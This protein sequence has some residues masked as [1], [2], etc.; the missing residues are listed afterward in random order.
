MRPREIRDWRNREREDW[1]FPDL[2]EID[3]FQ[4]LPPAT[5]F[6][7]AY[8]L[9]Y[10]SDWG[11][12]MPE[13]PPSKPLWRFCP[14]GNWTHWE[15]E[16]VRY[17]NRE[18]FSRFDGYNQG[19]YNGWWEDKRYLH[20]LDNW[21]LCNA[22]T[23]A[24]SLTNAQKIRV[25]SLFASRNLKRRGLRLEF[26]IFVLASLVCHYDGRKCYPHPNTKNYDPLFEEFARHHNFRDKMIRRWF[27][28]FQDQLEDGLLPEVKRQSPE[29]AANIE[30]WSL[31]GASEGRAQT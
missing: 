8:W 12:Q 18:Q 15:M 23:S 7:S 16:D 13:F 20:P 30:W 31:S 17:R 11:C 29:P 10:P 25:H 22:I 19:T 14:G 3:R 27:Q 28:R 4:F 6:K 5:S 2:R 26:V 9:D 1:D 24:L 21:Y